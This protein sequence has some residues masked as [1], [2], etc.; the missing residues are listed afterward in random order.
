MDPG[1][2]LLSK[3]ITEK[4]LVP[5]L[6]ARVTLDWFIDQE[7]YEVYT[8]VLKFFESFGAAPGP[9]A[10]EHE[11]PEYQLT[12]VD[13]PLEF[14]IEA[15]KDAYRYSQLIETLESVKEPL[16][17]GRSD[18]AIKSLASS[19]ERIQQEISPLTDIDFTENTEARLE[20][21][22]E[23]SSSPGLRG[24]TTGFP[25]MDKL[26]LGF[27]PEQL[28]T[29]V[30]TPKS[31]KSAVLLRMAI[32]S[33]LAAYRPMFLTFE[34]SNDEQAF[35]HDTFR[36]RISYNRLT[37]GSLTR[38]EKKRLEKMMRGLSAMP[39]M[40]FV[41]DVSSTTTVSGIAAKIAQIKPDIIYVDGVYLMDTELPGVEAFTA[42]GLTSITRSMKKLAQRTKKPIVQT[43][44]VLPGKYQRRR[45]VTL[46]SIGYTSSFA[47]DSDAIFG[48]EEIEGEEKKIRLRAVAGR[49]I[50]RNRIIELSWDWDTGTIEEIEEV[51]DEED[52]ANKFD[53]DDGH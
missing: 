6:D 10:L 48:A 39:P 31:G 37:S 43:T 22:R 24:I 7:H 42:Q 23:L 32:A 33:H 50:P 46:D 11:F 28:I 30:G 13:E 9:E 17:E 1:R 35:R 49:N 21:Y 25:T 44:Q 41:H 45:G 38:P 15:L 18:E 53:S 19:L 5:V 2:S 29:L 40:T 34:M 8:W 12:E 36:A 27:Q 52:L 20:Q 51:E 47:Q 26:T 4:T 16:S 3:I 14:Y